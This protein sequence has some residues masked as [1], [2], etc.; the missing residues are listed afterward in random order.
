MPGSSAQTLS[1]AGLPLIRASITTAP[2]ATAATWTRTNTQRARPARGA[3]LA[4]G[5]NR[6]A[7]TA[8]APRPAADGRCSPDP[9]WPG[10]RSSDADTAGTYHQSAL[11]T[12][13][14]AAPAA[15][16]T[17]FGEGR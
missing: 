17:G 4:G 9:V 6:S 10:A 7:S 11:H 8:R 15:G 5:E 12:Q 13:F 3:D 1:Q 16:R 14:Q 2:M